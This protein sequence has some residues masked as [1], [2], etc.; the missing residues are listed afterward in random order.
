MSCVDHT[1]LSA[2]GIKGGV[3]K[4]KAQRLDLQFN[5]AIFVHLNIVP[6]VEWRRLVQKRVSPTDRTDAHTAGQPSTQTS[7]AFDKF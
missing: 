7:Q 2:L 6:S 4:K 3:F 5:F 1:D